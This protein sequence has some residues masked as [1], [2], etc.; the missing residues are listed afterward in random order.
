METRA[1]NSRRSFYMSTLFYIILT[2]LKKT[3]FVFVLFIFISFIFKNT[4]YA[5]CTISDTLVNSCRPWLGAA[6]E[7]NPQTS[8]DPISQFTYLESLV[9]HPLDIFHDYHP[10]GSLP[11]NSNEIYFAKRSNTYI[12]VNWKPASNWLDADGGNAT[13][14][15]Q[16]D[17]AAASI[18]SVAPNK[19]FLTIWHE[20]ENDVSAF[21][22]TTEQNACDSDPEFG[23]LKGSAGTPAQYTAMWQNVENRF[24]ADGVTNV[25]YVMN[26]MNYRPWQCLVTYLWPGNNLVNWVTFEAYSTSDS[27]TWTS[28][29]SRMYNLLTNES[30]SNINFLSKP[31]GIGEFNDCVDDQAHVYQYYQEAKSALD[32]NIYPNL[33]L[34]MVFASTNGPDAGYGCLTNYAANG[35]YDPVKQIYFNQF[36][37]DPIFT[38]S[39]ISTPTETPQPSQTGLSVN[40][41]LDGIGRAGDNSNEKDSS[42]SNKNPLHTTITVTAQ[43]YNSNNVLATTVT[44][45]LQYSKISGSYTGT[46]YTSASLPMGYY[47]IKITANYHL[48][49]QVSGNQQLTPGQVNQ[50]PSVELIAGDVNNDNQLNIL[51]YNIIMNCYSDLMPAKSCNSTEKAETDLNDDENVNQID[52][53][54]FLRELSNLQGD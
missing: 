39:S 5:A 22:N 21:D 17:Q 36:A 25:V 9:G 38:N 19:I 28:V 41:L 26:Y 34:Y 10:A 15:A 48:T 7:G 45:N 53:N 31:W 47:I 49:R 46:I 4:A 3:F 54:L 13:I 8:S 14:N 32:A 1:L 11:L 51:D 50:I 24:A 27:D 30:N 12:Y 23:A 43:I 6:A 33:K 42:A 20:P 35:T 16:I 52:Y 18:K 44:G 2:I 37:D 29:V 40:V